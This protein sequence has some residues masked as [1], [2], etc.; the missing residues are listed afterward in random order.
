MCTHT[1]IYTVY[2]NEM[3][4]MYIYTYV[5]IYTFVNRQH[6]ICGLTCSSLTSLILRP[7]YSCE[8]LHLQYTDR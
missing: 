3:K 2:I 4:Y 8:V 5:Y 6:Q 7:L 1:K